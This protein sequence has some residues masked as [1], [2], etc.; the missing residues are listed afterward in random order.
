MSTEGERYD[1]ESN[2]K[3]GGFQSKLEASCVSSHNDELWY[4][5]TVCLWVTIYMHGPFFSRNKFDSM[6]MYSDEIMQSLQKLI[7]FL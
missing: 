7:F 2:V 4:N 1:T 3:L 5:E 6:K